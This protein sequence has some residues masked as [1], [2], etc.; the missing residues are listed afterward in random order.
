MSQPY[1]LAVRDVG[2]ASARVP[3]VYRVKAWGAFALRFAVQA[4]QDRP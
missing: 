1:D 3:E 2:I 4:T